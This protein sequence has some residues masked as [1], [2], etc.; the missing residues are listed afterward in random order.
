MKTF[1]AILLGLVIILALSSFT[2]GFLDGPLGIVAGGPL[3]SG[4]LVP[5]EGV[6]FSFAKN[7]DTIEFQLLDPPRS[8]TTWVILYDESLFVPAGF[9]NL[10][11]WKQWPHEAVN[12]GRAIVRIEGIRYPF[13]LERVEDR[14]TW[15]KVGQLAAKKYGLEE[16]DP[17]GEA[18]AE[19]WNEFWVFRMSPESLEAME[20]PQ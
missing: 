13:R 12:D 4:D 16:I 14:K 5:S 8:R 3:T 1:G 19:R 18:S 7:I 15:Q 9:M 11:I 20:L 6:D 10:P 2:V 17:Q